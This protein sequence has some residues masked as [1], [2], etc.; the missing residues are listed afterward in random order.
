MNDCKPCQISN[1][2]LYSAG[3]CVDTGTNQP[4]KPADGGKSCTSRVGVGICPTVNLC[5]PWD[6]TAMSD[7]NCLAE[8]AI[9][10]Q[11]NI[12]GAQ[13]N[14]HKLLGVH[15]Q[16]LLDDLTNNGFAISS[17]DLPGN[18]AINAFDQFI[19]EWRSAQTGTDVVAKTYIGYDF[20]PLRLDNGR[21]R[22]TDTTFIHRDVSTLRIKQG[23]DSKNRATKIRVERSPDGEKW[24]GVAIIDLQDCDGLLTYNFRKTV[25]SR[26]WRIRPL[27]FN[28]G[29][30]DYW[31]IQALQFADYEITSEENIQDRIFLENRDRDY[32]E[33]PLKLKAQYSP[34]DKSLAAGKFGFEFFSEDYE[35]K[36]SFRQVVRTLGRPFIIGD[37]LELPSET[38]FNT[39]LSP[40]KKYLEV[41]DVGWDSQSFT[42]AW[43]PTMQ[44]VV[45]KPVVASQETQDIMGKLT[46]TVDSS[47]LFDIDDGNSGKK[48]QDYH[49]IS[50]TI[51][52]DA[53][54]QV[55]QKG[56]DVGDLAV[57]S[58]ELKQ[59][60]DGKPDMNLE[61]LSRYHSIYTQDAL[62]PNG[63]PYTQG[64]T[65]PSNPKDGDFHRL[66]YDTISP[67][68]PA[69][70]HVYSA[71]K[72]RWLFV[73]SDVKKSI[74]AVKPRLQDFLN[75]KN[76]KRVNID[77]I[78]K[79]V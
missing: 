33:A 40:I 34:F 72:S 75:P 3:N 36:F 27:Q 76:R 4:S 60:S 78:K 9:E 24:F 50:Q 13:I 41:T 20:G 55:P 15:E 79:E 2:P 11:L 65:F 74:N 69:R 43:V 16:G 42:A 1:D 31:S 30:N 66:T 23:C 51:K 10:E 62:P 25:P 54:T 48:Y 53:L 56:I 18:P 46:K 64:D 73:Q 49:D 67:N 63:L 7:V 28:G 6:I 14:V 57:I 19:T 8:S 61:K 32:S 44:R 45:A 12:A 26:W 71:A 17:G 52:A 59:F 77:D 22:Y 70:L 37:I 35:L 21:E 5:S 39:R 47:G 38:Q 58:P 68:I 29:Q